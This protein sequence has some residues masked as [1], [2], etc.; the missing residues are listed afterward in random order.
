MLKIKETIA[1]TGYKTNAKEVGPTTWQSSLLACI[2]TLTS[3]AKNSYNLTVQKKG[4]VKF[5][6]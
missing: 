1:G 3:A 2:S 5:V 4:L 6:L